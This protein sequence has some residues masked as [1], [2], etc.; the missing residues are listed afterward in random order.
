MKIV[1]LDIETSPLES[2]TWGLLDQN[3]GLDM[4]KTEWSILSFAAKWADKPGVLYADTGGRGAATVRDDKVLMEPL[5]NIL[6]GADIVVSQNGISFDMKKINTR[7]AIHGFGPYSPVRHV[8]TL[9]VSRK[10][11]GNTSNKLA[12]LSKH[13][14]PNTVKSTHKKFP[15]FELWR[16]CLLDNPAAWAEMKKYNI[17]DVMATEA[18]WLK[19]RPWIVGHPDMSAPNASGAVCPKCSSTKLHSKGFIVTRTGKYQQRQCQACGGW[20]RSNEN[21]RDS[22]QRKSLQVSV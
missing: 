9:R 8:D 22:N 2:Y 12:W 14:V 5:W 16:Q 15:G 21:L 18:L 1:V 10:H 13:M 7:L 20:S 19:L 11:F 3:I 17:Q 6:D 4:I